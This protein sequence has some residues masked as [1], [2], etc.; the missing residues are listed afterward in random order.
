MKKQQFKVNLSSGQFVTIDGLEESDAKVIASKLKGNLMPFSVARADRTA[1]MLFR[2]ISIDSANLL[3]I[4][5][6]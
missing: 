5:S 2:E 3:L 6:L 4:S 1:N